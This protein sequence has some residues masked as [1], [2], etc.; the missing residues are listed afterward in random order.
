MLWG[1]SAGGSSVANYPYAFAKDPIVT[2][3]IADSGATGFSGRNSDYAHTNFTFLAGKLGCGGLGPAAEVACMRK[4]PA[5]KIQSTLS[6]YANSGQKP[7]VA[8]VPI[9]DGVTGFKNYTERLLGGH[10]AQV[11]SIKQ[12][13]ET[14]SYC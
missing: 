7:A 11:V 13:S 10:L 14:L 1:Q 4:V 3:L 2:G 5:L 8:F 9:A 12:R 6:N